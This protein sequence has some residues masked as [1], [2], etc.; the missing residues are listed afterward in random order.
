[1]A[2]T[3]LE[4]YYA[5]LMAHRAFAIEARAMLYRRHSSDARRPRL[6]RRPFCLQPLLAQCWRSSRHAPRMASSAQR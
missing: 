3:A 6:L 5:M 4:C 1:M 2:G